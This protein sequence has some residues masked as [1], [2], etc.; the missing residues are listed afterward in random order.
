MR[1]FRAR[2]H[3]LL[4]LWRW[5]DGALFGAAPASPCAPHLQTGRAAEDAA[6]RYLSAQGYRIVERNVSCG[7]GELDIVATRDD[8][9]VVVEVKAGRRSDA[10][11]PREKVD[12]AKQRQ[13]LK[14][15]EAYRKRHRLLDLRVR[16]DVVEVV[17]GP[18]GVPQIEHFIGAVEERQR[19][20]R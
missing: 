9:L 18:D 7:R 10:Y 19:D 8:W 14:T 1:E 3:W 2:E 5:L 12:A 6:A 16:I 4:P 17:F 13:L 11:L 15:T 20:R